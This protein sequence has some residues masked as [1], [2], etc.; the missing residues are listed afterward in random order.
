MK[1]V[2]KTIHKK[3]HKHLKLRHRKHTGKLLAHKH[4]SYR[5]LF[6]LM[7]AP[8]G[9]MSL[10]QNLDASAVNNL[11]VSAKVPVL[12]PSGTPVIQNP[13][14]GAN[15][16]SSSVTVSGTCPLSNSL[17]IISIYEGATLLGSTPCT[18]S[19]TFATSIS[20]G[21]G[22][23]TINATVVM[24]T[25]DIG[26]TSKKVTFK[27]D[28]QLLNN[29]QITSPSLGLPPQL[30]AIEN[31]VSVGSDGGT[32][33]RFSIKGGATPYSVNID[34]GDGNTDD[35]TV[36]SHE[37]Q[38]F[39]H[40]YNDDSQQ[41]IVYVKVVDANN[42][43]SEFYTVAITGS[44][45]PPAIGLGL[46]SKV[47]SIPPLVTFV[48]QHALQIY[49]GSFFALVFLWYLEHGHIMLSRHLGIHKFRLFHK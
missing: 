16:L 48:Q 10:V 18:G 5:V 6:A 25:G 1:S 13:I 12:V 23:H 14:N 7:L 31:F 46:D 49:V 15:V 38:S 32:T 30:I 45:R 41:Y 9:M 22:T 11:G 42:V 44:Y 27:L 43:S 21:Y 20:V 47:E 29:K 36:K 28:S 26:K 17:V 40:V 34:W 33:Y 3:I 8:I 39:Y 4:T 37:Q 24:V 2:K 19:G 35:Y